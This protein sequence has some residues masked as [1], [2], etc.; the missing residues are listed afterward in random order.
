MDSPSWVKLPKKVFAGL[1][2]VPGFINRLT[3]EVSARS[4]YWICRNA[5]V[6]GA[7]LAATADAREQEITV[8]GAAPC[9]H[10]QQL[11]PAAD[12]P[13]GLYFALLTRAGGDA[14]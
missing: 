5:E 2:N 11:L 4:M 9:A 6:V 1:V 12:G 10:G 8:P 13:D 14:A 7:F 3:D